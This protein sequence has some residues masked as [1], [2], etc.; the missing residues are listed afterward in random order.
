MFHLNRYIEIF[1]NLFS[2][3]LNVSKILK[4]FKCSSTSHEVERLET[5]SSTKVGQVGQASN[6]P[7]WCICFACIWDMTMV[8]Y[9]INIHLDIDLSIDL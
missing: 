8:G 3:D 7:D 2:D 6:P 1:S 4:N 5:G 9:R